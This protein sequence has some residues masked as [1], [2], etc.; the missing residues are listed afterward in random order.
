MD[1]DITL[2]DVYIILVNFDV[3]LPDIDIII[4]LTVWDTFPLKK[5]VF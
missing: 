3:I 1:V 4:I 2:L 5:N